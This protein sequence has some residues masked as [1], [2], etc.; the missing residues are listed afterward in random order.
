MPAISGAHHVQLGPLIVGTL[1]D[2]KHPAFREFPTASYADW[3]WWDILNYATALEL[4]GLHG[5]TPIV[6]SIDSYES[7]HKLG[8]AFEARVGKGHLFVLCVDIDKD[9]DKRE[10]MR[11]LLHSVKG[12]VS[13]DAFNPAK[14]VKFHQLDAL[15]APPANPK[16]GEKENAA[17]KQ[18]LNQ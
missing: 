13:S 12:Y 11:Q 14:E 5:I 6:Q 4:D 9:M 18:L 17:I 2:D 3:Q 7:N 15:F 10:A 1:I 16:A 8:I